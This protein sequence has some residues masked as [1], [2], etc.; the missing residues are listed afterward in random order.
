MKDFHKESRELSQRFRKHGYPNSTI[1]QAKVKAW[2]KQREKILGL[3]LDNE[4]LDKS[5][6]DSGDW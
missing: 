1:T 3:E 2:K 4:K 6:R 5:N